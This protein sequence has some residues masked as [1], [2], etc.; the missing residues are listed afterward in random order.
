MA[1][2]QSVNSTTRK[3]NEIM[4]LYDEFVKLNLITQLYDEETK[5][6]AFNYRLLHYYGFTILYSAHEK[7]YF[8]VD[9]AAILH[10]KFILVESGRVP[11]DVLK[12]YFEQA[13]EKET[14]FS[15]KCQ[16]NKPF[17]V[18]GLTSIT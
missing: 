5:T 4:S 17:N 9:S 2:E 18:K 10:G 7:E 6:I 16:K 3:I 12:S 11:I 1:N 15:K 13:D 14:S 8:M